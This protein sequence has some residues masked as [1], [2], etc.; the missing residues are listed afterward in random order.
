M[1][2][3]HIPNMR[4]Y[5]S[6]GEMYQYPMLRGIMTREQFQTYRRFL[7]FNNNNGK[8]GRGDYSLDPPADYDIIY[9]WRPMMDHFNEAWSSLMHTSEY[10]AFDEMMIKLAM[11]SKLSR[12]Q[13]NKPI[14]DGIQ[15]YSVCESKGQWCYWSWIDQGRLCTGFRG[16]YA[17]GWIACMCLFVLRKLNIRNKWHTVIFDQYFTSPILFILL[18]LDG[19][20]AVGT[21]QTNRLGFP[22]RMLNGLGQL[23]ADTVQCAHHVFMHAYRLVAVKW[24]DK[25]DVWFLS[26]KHY[27]SNMTNYEKLQKGHVEPIDSFQPEV[28]EFYNDNNN[29]VDIVDQRDSAY[30]TDRGSKTNPWHRVHLHWC[31]LSVTQAQTHYRMVKKQHTAVYTGGMEQYVESSYYAS[32]FRWRLF[33]LMAAECQEGRRRNMG[34]GRGNKRGCR[35]GRKKVGQGKCARYGCGGRTRH[36]CMTCGKLFCIPNGKCKRNCFNKHVWKNCACSD[37]FANPEWESE[38]ESESGSEGESESERQSE[39]KSES[40]S[41]SESESGSETES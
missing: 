9:N 3:V 37:T 23:V 33:Q 10:L 38:S 36:G 8:V 28:R 21:C 17:H 6:T 41:E 11:K 35:L 39:S 22:V 15:V 31:A 19:V 24:L 26:T 2:M 34:S 27:C 12:R 40:G 29:G 5:W 18:L 16:P 30:L 7:H 4:D 32:K 1:G 20:Y 14:R 13:P 25:K